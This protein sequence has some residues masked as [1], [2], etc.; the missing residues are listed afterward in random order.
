M[1]NEELALRMTKLRREKEE[2][3]QEDV[4]GDED[5]ETDDDGQKITVLP[6]YDCALDV[7]DND[8]NNAAVEE[9]DGKEVPQSEE[10][11]GRC[12]YPVGLFGRGE[13]PLDTCQGT[14]GK[15][16]GFHHACNVN[17]LGSNGKDA[18]LCKLCYI[19]MQSI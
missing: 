6:H 1:E 3:K 10:G 13:P 2:A 16:N 7:Y 8:A 9:H 15:K 12:K 5:F 18:E 14:C 17:W 11:C 19:C 4:R